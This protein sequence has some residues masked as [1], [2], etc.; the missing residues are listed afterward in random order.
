[1]FIVVAYDVVDDRRRAQLCHRLKSFGTRVQYSVFECLLTPRDFARLHT[2]VAGI[3]KPGQDQ[4]RYY[5]L[6]DACRQ[7]V[8]AVGDTVTR[9]PRTVVI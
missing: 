8:Q 1:M 2:V 6:C 3:I 7:R 9:E 4:V 5:R